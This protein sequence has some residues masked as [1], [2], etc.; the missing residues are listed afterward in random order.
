[1]ARTALVN[2]ELKNGVTQLTKQW[3]ELNSAYVT[4]ARKKLSSHK[5]LLAS[6]HRHKNSTESLTP[7][8]TKTTSGSNYEKSFSLTTSQF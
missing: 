7:M 2:A 6:G 5:R 3:R 4:F 8:Q 1:M